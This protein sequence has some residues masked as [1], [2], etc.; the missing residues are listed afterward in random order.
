MVQE[1]EILIIGGGLAGLT[2]AIHL[3][4]AGRQVTLIE[5]NVYP[6]HKVCGEYISNEVLDYLKWLGADPSILEPSKITDLQFSTLD[7]KVVSCKLP[8]GGFGISRHALDQYLCKRAIALGCTVVQDT[9][10]RIQYSKDEFTV[11]AIEN[12]FKAV[13]VLG[14]YGKRDALDYTLNRKFISKKSPWI[15]VKAHYKGDFPEHLVALHN[16]TGGYCGVSRVEGGMINLCYLVNYST[17][18]KYKNI[19]ELQ[20]NVIRSNPHLNEIFTKCSMLSRS[21]LSIGQISFKKKHTIENHVLMIGDSAGLIH[22]LCGNG[23]SMAI[24]SAKI[25]SELIEQYFSSKDKSR[26]K[27]ER[28]YVESWNKTF[29]KRLK[30]GHMLSLVLKSQNLT[31]ILLKVLLTFPSLFQFIIKQTH[32]KPLTTVS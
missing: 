26:E 6:Q 19:D 11:D 12:S 9:V 8:L 29:D 4:K 14:A 21:P 13:I 31:G 15:A 32:G 17:F 24:H 10:K 20:E 2:S 25:S 3:A 1:T 30:M 23:M 5:K 7:G 18:K 16:F 22:P 27:L 28:G